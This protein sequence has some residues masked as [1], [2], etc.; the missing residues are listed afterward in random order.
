[1]ENCVLTVRDNEHNVGDDEATSPDVAKSGTCGN[2]ELTT[3]V[4]VRANRY[5]PLGRVGAYS[6]VA[7]VLCGFGA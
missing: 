3:H 2:W 6:A 1:M 7:W 5:R 4:H